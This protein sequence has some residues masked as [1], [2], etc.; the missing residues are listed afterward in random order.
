MAGWK[1]R[2]GTFREQTFLIKWILSYA[3]VPINLIH[4]VDVGRGEGRKSE[5]S[6]R[7]LIFGST[8]REKSDDGSKVQIILENSVR[9]ERFAHIGS[10][11]ISRSTIAKIN[12][13]ILKRKLRYLRVRVLAALERFAA[14]LR[15]QKILVY[16]REV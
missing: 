13:S 11:V 3:V 6:S 16:L 7:N 14:K 12:S 8:A 5:R 2:P 9:T 1:V 10:A 15:L 4:A